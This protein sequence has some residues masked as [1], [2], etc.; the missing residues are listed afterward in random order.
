MTVALKATAAS[1]LRD[2]E[3]KWAASVPAGPRL[4]SAAIIELAGD[5]A[6]PSP[7]KEQ[8][9]GA[10]LTAEGLVAL[11]FSDGYEGVADLTKTG[12]RIDRL[13]L[14]SLRPSSWGGSA[15]VDDQRGHTVHIDSSVLR[16]IIDPAYAA[17]LR[18]AIAA[19]ADN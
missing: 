17:V 10:S 11:R 19:L 8:L 1:P 12:L 9:V 14:A 3:P 16:A 15:E 5:D 2:I 13:D 6:I 18:S 4:S 7:S